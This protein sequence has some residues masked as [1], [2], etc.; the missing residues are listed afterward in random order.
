MNITYGNSQGK[1]FTQWRFD[2]LKEV[3]EGVNQR[4]GVIDFNIYYDEY[5]DFHHLTFELNSVKVDIRFYKRLGVSF[6]GVDSDR[7]PYASYDYQQLLMYINEKTL[8]SKAS[9]V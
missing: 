4:F 1:W 7:W 5:H 9:N 6:D 3:A 2:L 8:A